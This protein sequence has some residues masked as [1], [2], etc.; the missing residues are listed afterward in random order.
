MC[1]RSRLSA[2]HDRS[3]VPAVPSSPNYCPLITS[4][5]LEKLTGAPNP[6]ILNSTHGRRHTVDVNPPSPPSLMLSHSESDTH[7]G[8][9]RRKF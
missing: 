1:D 2:T 4:I 9:E 6:K 3:S 7:K 8:L 5:S